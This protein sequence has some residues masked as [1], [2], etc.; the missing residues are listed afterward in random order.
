[1]AD[2]G[3]NFR[4]WAHIFVNEKILLSTDPVAVDA[5]GAAWIEKARKEKGY[6]PF[7]KAKNSIP[8]VE[9]RPP[10]HIATAA[11]RGL[12]TDDPD[13]MDIRRIDIPALPK[14]A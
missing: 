4:S 1:M 14:K 2:G 10:K 12:G 9:G 7:A 11:A 13:R 5:L 8:K 6:P 3:P